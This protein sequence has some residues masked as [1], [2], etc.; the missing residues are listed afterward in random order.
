MDSFLG[1][2]VKMKL[3][4]FDSNKPD[5]QYILIWEYNDR[6]WA[7]PVLLENNKIIAEFCHETDW[8]KY[9]QGSFITP[10]MNI[11]GYLSKQD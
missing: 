6:I 3:H 2:G 4:S 7:E 1:N 8:F 10:E 5:G 9:I 11:I